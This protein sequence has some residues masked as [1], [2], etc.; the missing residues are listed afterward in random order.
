MFSTTYRF[1][2]LENPD[3]DFENLNPDFPV[4]CEIRK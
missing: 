4:E 3:L 2:R 1:V